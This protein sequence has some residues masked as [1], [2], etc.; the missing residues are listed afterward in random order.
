MYL[1]N[2]FVTVLCLKS[3][4]MSI[5]KMKGNKASDDLHMAKFNYMLSHD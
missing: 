4:K 1:A 2:N 5:P 3:L